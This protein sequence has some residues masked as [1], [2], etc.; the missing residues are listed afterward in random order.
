MI[1]NAKLQEILQY[2][3]L[4]GKNNHVN[5]CA[6]RGKTLSLHKIITGKI[7]YNI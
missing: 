1:S 3:L 4:L 5:V 2:F 7:R 6:F